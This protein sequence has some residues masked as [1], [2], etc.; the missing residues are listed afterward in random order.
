[1]KG[2]LA[3]GGLFVIFEDVEAEVVVSCDP[4]LL[5]GVTGVTLLD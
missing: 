1:M 2:I 4:C 5:D 3:K